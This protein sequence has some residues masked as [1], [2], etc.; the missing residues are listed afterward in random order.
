MALVRPITILG[1][2]NM[3]KIKQEMLKLS[4][5]YHRGDPHN[6]SAVRAGKR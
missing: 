1:A 2:L 4:K 6:C 3:E 5:N